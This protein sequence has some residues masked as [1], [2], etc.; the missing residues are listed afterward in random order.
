ML[1][2]ATLRNRVLSRLSEY[3]AGETPSGDDATLVEAAY[4]RWYYQL[5][6]KNAVSWPN[7]G[8]TVE[9][10]PEW[11]EADLITIIAAEVADDYGIDE[12]QT[13][14]LLAMRPEAI[15]N[16]KGLAAND[17]VPDATPASYY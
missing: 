13:Q 3:G 8:N 2:K 16:L 11:A 14:R 9:E 17:Y 4:D 10:I 12:G 6:R 5:A 7:T 15:R 1:S